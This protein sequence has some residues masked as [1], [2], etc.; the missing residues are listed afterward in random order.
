MKWNKK[1]EDFTRLF[2][3]R[4]QSFYPP[5]SSISLAL[6]YTILFSVHPSVL[7]S[8]QPNAQK[9]NFLSDFSVWFCWRDKFRIAIACKWNWNVHTHFS[10]KQKQSFYINSSFFLSVGFGCWFL[11]LWPFMLSINEGERETEH[12]SIFNQQTTANYDNV[13]KWKIETILSY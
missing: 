10:L 9:L 4:I 2:W 8:R 1:E 3:V 12:F 5:P 6:L 13:S 7:A 11:L